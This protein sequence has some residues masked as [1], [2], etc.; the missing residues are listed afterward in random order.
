M[1]Q[2]LRAKMSKLCLPTYMHT[3]V[4]KFQERFGIRSQGTL[5]SDIKALTS[6]LDPGLDDKTPVTLPSELIHP[7]AAWMGSSQK[8]PCGSL[9]PQEGIIHKEVNHL[10]VSFKPAS[11]SSRDSNIVFH[12]H[13]QTLAAARIYHIFSIRVHRETGGHDWYTLCAVRQFSELSI[14]DAA[15]DVYRRFG[16]YSGWVCYTEEGCLDIIQLQ[17]IWCHVALTPNVL[18][19]IKSHHIHILPLDRVSEEFCIIID[20]INIYLPD[21]VLE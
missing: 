2:S 20:L 4:D 14:V 15:K 1:G 11:R 10:G 21:L 13:T 12:S 17:D 7:L 18:P 5:A 8:I 19:L 6:P 3:V 16:V 9:T